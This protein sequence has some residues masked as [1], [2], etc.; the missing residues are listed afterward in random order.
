MTKSNRPILV[1][2]LSFAVV[3]LVGAKR[4]IGGDR[5]LRCVALRIGVLAAT[6]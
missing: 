6:C 4:I 3:P 5:G 2:V 1:T